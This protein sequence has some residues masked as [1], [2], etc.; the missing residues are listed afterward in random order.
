M[1]DAHLDEGWLLD[2]AV[3]HGGWGGGMGVG[4]AYMEVRPGSSEPPSSTTVCVSEQ[5]HRCHC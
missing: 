5:R 4:N 1:T 2:Q 3:A